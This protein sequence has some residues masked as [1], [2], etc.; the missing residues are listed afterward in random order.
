M[1]F[2]CSQRC[3]A[4]S[5]KNCVSLMLLNDEKKWMV[6][7][8]F[9]ALVF[10]CNPASF[11]HSHSSHSGCFRSLRK[12]RKILKMGAS[13]MSLT[14][15]DLSHYRGSKSTRSHNQTPFKK[16][17][18][19]SSLT[20]INALWMTWNGIAQQRKT[21]PRQ[22]PTLL[23]TR[24]AGSSWGL[25][26]PLKFALFSSNASCMPIWMR[27]SFK[28]NVASILNFGKYNKSSCVEV[29]ARSNNWLST[30]GRDASFCSTVFNETPLFGKMTV[31]TNWI[32][33]FVLLYGRW[34]TC[35]CKSLFSR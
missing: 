1:A 13:L 34:A 15:S 6:D 35:T 22:S 7:F 10:S 23:T 30:A 11:R 4:T 19:P 24:P 27:T 29:P 16:F 8:E 21:R 5:E 25:T 32:S 2:S 3:A 14:D 17:N 31:N 12:E 28:L 33:R 20:S 26:I 18:L 9:D